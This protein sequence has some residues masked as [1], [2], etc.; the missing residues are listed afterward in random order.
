M[1][2]EN[3]R[4]TPEQIAEAREMLKDADDDVRDGISLNYHGLQALRVLIAATKPP[5][6]MEIAY[7]ALLG[8]GHLHPKPDAVRFMCATIQGNTKLAAG[9]IPETVQVFLGKPK[10]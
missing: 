6:Y 1:S 10:P 7:A 3:T 4:P 2:N 9:Y 5:T 8:A